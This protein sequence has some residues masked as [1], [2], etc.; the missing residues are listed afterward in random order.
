M[1][2]QEYVNFKLYYNRL[3]SRMFEL[4]KQAT[5]DYY[6]ALL[7]ANQYRSYI[8]IYDMECDEV[9]AEIAANILGNTYE[10]YT[11]QI[12]QLI[13]NH[14]A[15]EGAKEELISLSNQILLFHKRDQIPIEQELDKDEVDKSC[16]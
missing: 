10:K 11:E 13:V 9:Q 5:E 2:A 15:D 12:E 1:T 14:I 7:L 6:R 3:V 8:C 4:E 16:I